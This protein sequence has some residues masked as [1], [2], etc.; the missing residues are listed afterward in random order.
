[1]TKRDRLPGEHTILEP[2]NVVVRELLWRVER[3]ALFGELVD[4]YA[5]GVVARNLVIL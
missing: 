5:G 2:G 1:M 4:L 3:A